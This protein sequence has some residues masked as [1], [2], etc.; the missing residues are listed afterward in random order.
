MRMVG[1]VVSMVSGNALFATEAKAFA[2]L[3]VQQKNGKGLR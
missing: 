2:P 3:M 1:T